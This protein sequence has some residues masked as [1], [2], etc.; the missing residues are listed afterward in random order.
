M[1][2][3]SYCHLELVFLI[4]SIFW[5]KHCLRL[6]IW[7]KVANQLVPN[8]PFIF[9]TIV[10]CEQVSLIWDDLNLGRCWELRWRVVVT[11]CCQ[12]RAFH[13]NETK[14]GDCSKVVFGKKAPGANDLRCRRALNLKTMNSVALKYEKICQCT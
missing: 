14:T 3:W 4:H 10:G 6:I 2:V 13:P 12:F 7:Q 9:V 8:F 1:A 5:L 11:Y